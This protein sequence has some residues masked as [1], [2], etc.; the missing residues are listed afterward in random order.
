MKF[1]RDVYSDPNR[2]KDLKQMVGSVMNALDD[3]QNE[4]AMKKMKKQ[5]VKFTKDYSFNRSD[6]EDQYQDEEKDYAVTKNV[7][8][9]AVEVAKRPKYQLIASVMYLM[10]FWLRKVN[11][12]TDLLLKA[13]S[14]S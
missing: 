6:V 11:R 14:K 9:T 13:G 3:V 8:L 5:K 1:Y 7:S 10:N 4:E 2:S 12:R